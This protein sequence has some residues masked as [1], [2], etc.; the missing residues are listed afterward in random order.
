MTHSPV[1]SVIVPMYNNESSLPR[2]VDSVISQTF[3]DWEIVL[4]DDGSRDSTSEIVVRSISIPS[5]ER[6]GELQA[7][8]L[9]MRSIPPPGCGNPGPSSHDTVSAGQH[10]PAAA[11]LLYGPFRTI[12][13]G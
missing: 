3:P 10:V 9:A 6:S 12:I 4:V 11:S 2:A 7:T 5:S 1:V 13:S 8:C